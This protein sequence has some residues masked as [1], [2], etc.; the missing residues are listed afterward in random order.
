MSVYGKYTVDH[1]EVRASNVFFVHGNALQPSLPPGFR[2]EVSAESTDYERLPTIFCYPTAKGL[3]AKISPP[4][5]IDLGELRSIEVDLKSG[6]NNV[7]RGVL[8]VRPATAGLRLRIAD[9]SIV[10][11]AIEIRDSADSG[12]IEFANFEADSFVRFRI[13]YSV[14]ADHNTLLARLEVSYETAS[15]RFSYSSATSIIST[16]PINVN[17]QDVFKDDVLFSRFT[18]GPAMSTPVRLLNCRMRSSEIYK[19][20]SSMQ[21]HKI[22]DVFPKQPASLLCKIMQPEGRAQA[23]QAKKRAL[24]LTID[25]NCLDEECLTVIEERFRA[26]IEASPFE[27]LSRLLIPHLLELFRSRWTAND[28]ETIGLLREVEIPSYESA[29]WESITGTLGPEMENEI[30]LWLVEWHKVG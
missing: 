11:G 5:H 15:G 26:D 4:H 2:E 17:V 18:I 21:E 9:A 6:W 29:Q 20:Q 10:S 16:L 14:E 23:S 19:V 30:K 8:R 1:L 12:N 25:F 24:A 7:L 13:P 3:E 28:F 22:L 27:H